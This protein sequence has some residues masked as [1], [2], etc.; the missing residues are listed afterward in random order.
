MKRPHLLQT[1]FQEAAATASELPWARSC[2]PANCFPAPVE[3]PLV[4]TSSLT[5]R[6]KGAPWKPWDA[7]TD[8][9]SLGV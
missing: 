3:E 9:D 4:G 1:W 5:Q 8:S 2:D 6:L 7:F